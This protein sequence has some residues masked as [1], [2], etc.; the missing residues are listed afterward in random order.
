MASAKVILH[1]ATKSQKLDGAYPLALRITKDR[2]T[3]F[4]F[5]GVYVQEKDWDAI[6]QKV[7]KSNQNAVHINN[8]ILKKLGKTND[9][10]IESDAQERD[11]TA[12]QVKKQ[13]KR[14]GS[15]ISFQE[16]AEEHY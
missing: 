5:L 3:K 12:L 16:F 14:Q 9:I 6:P 1:K 13:M 2:R 11:V 7:K 8:L 10:L 4:I 15:N